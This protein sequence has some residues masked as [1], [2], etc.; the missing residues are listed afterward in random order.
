MTC[1]G[2]QLVHT[3]LLQ[4]KPVKLLIRASRQSLSSSTTHVR[5]PF[6]T[7]P[8]LRIP[9]Q[10]H[11][12]SSC[13]SEALFKNPPPFKVVSSYRSPSHPTTTDLLVSIGILPVSTTGQ[14]VAAH[15][16]LLLCK[17]QLCFMRHLHIQNI[18]WGSENWDKL[19][20]SRLNSWTIVPQKVKPAT[21][22]IVRRYQQCSLL[23]PPQRSAH[24]LS[25][26]RLGFEPVKLGS[27]V[28]PDMQC[29]VTG[30]AI[31]AL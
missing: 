3:R 25:S 20:C 10:N 29:R 21:Y 15:L 2:P 22:L 17:V 12:W 18:A 14:A 31:W 26:T 8:V 23:P 4:T 6:Q 1:I 30:R 24:S 11:T 7:P 19:I 16:P 28:A 13:D 27:P 5:L 9:S